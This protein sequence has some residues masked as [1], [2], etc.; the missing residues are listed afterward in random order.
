MVCH[1]CQAAGTQSEVEYG[2][3]MMGEVPS[4]QERYRGRVLR[5]ECGEDM[6]LGLLVGHMRMQHGR[7]VE[8]RRSWAAATLGE[9][10]RTTRMAFPTVGGPRKFPVEGYPGRAAI[11]KAMRLHFLHRHVRDTVVILELGN[12][13]HPQCPCCDMLVP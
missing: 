4:Y 11:R 12:L 5:K 3:R 10:L 8:R 2:I 6:E 9:E 7:A 13:P 1:P